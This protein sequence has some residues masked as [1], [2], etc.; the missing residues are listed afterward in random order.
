[1]HSRTAPSRLQPLGAMLLAGL[2]PLAPM[3]AQ[4]AD[5]APEPV[6]TLPTVRVEAD[7]EKPQGALV[8]TTR[9]GKTL[10]NPQDIPQAITS[11]PQ[12]ILKEQQAASLKEAMRNVAGVSFNAAEGGRGGDNMNLRSYYTFGDMY[13]DGIRD[14]AQYNRDTFNLEQV[15]VLRGA[16]AMLFGRGQAGGVIN[17][18]TK[19]PKAKT[20]GEVSVAVGTH[21][22]KSIKADV[23]GAISEDVGIRVNAMNRTEGS[24]RSNPV[25][26]T[27][28]ETNRRGVAASL[29]L[30]QSKD[31][32]FWVNYLQ[33]I[34]RDI[35]DFG[36]SFDASTRRPGTQ[37]ATSNFFGTN[38][39]FDDSDTE[40]FT[41]I[42]ETRLS[43]TQKLRTQLRQADYQRTYWAK[44]PNL[45]ATPDAQNVA[46]G[47]Q[48]RMSH[49]KTTTLQ[50]DYTQS[51]KLGGMSHD[52]LAGMEWL[53]ESNSRRALTN[54]GG[55]TTANPPNFQ[56]YTSSATPTQFDGTSYAVYVQDT[57]E[58]VPDWK[59]TAGVRRDDL[60]ATYSS[61][62]SPK[63]HF[64]ENSYRAAVSWQP[65][66][67][68]HYYVGWSDSFSPTADLYQLTSTPQPP[69]R[70]AVIEMGAKWLL[71]NGDLALRTAIYQATKQYERNT[72]VETTAALLTRERRTRG[73]EIDLAGH[74]TENWEVFGGLSLMNAKILAVA[75]NTNA[76]TGVVTVG[77]EGFVGKRARNTP[78]YALTFWSTYKIDGNW[79][80]GGG[81]EVQGDRLAYQP[82]SATL[83][84]LNGEFHPNTAPSYVRWDAL[85]HYDKSTWTASLNIKNVFDK[86]YYES[87]YDNGGFT[88]PG[89]RRTVILSAT[90]RF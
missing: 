33:Q 88:V 67:Q 65:S 15:D 40:M 66:D 11:V 81:A 47:N 83:P 78:E 89:P 84:T 38:Q 87:V 29:A 27:E 86:V 69:E 32:K 59:V 45:T 49:Y 73:L 44:T 74:L 7:A 1:M 4:A 41:L 72:D 8:T 68:T 64:G 6:K 56:P 3:S 42:N 16:G 14:T 80:V 26:G 5:A 22:H 28:P 54:L 20:G 12:A 46:G 60:R 58:V 61:A 18:V 50:S 70:S 31:S 52:F 34:T 57:V 21:D 85:V 36:V 76:T 82:Q 30:N 9:V 51:F 17:Q 35:P 77:N 19:L 43:G 63:L 24:W 53:K 79:Q 48:T 37:Q 25:T 75:T 39:N 55:T 23:N 90:R 71:F 2:A 13:L 10:Q 62:S